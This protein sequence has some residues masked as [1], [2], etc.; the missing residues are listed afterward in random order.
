MRGRGGARLGRGRRP[1]ICYNAV[2]AGGCAGG[3]VYL[4][5]LKRSVPAPEAGLAPER[6]PE[7]GEPVAA[8]TDRAYTVEQMARAWAAIGRPI[9]EDD[10]PLSVDPDDYP[11]F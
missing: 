6:G 5:Q 8:D 3:H 4:V 1:S 7:T 11:L 2:G 9:T 10:V